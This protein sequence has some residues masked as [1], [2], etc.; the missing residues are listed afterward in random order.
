MEGSQGPGTPGIFVFREMLSQAKRLEQTRHVASVIKISVPSNRG[1]SK[2]RGLPSG[3]GRGIPPAFF[4]RR[5]I[6]GSA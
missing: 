2:S 4:M 1:T 6:A 5:P 3:K